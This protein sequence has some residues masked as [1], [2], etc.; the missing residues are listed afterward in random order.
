MEE[1]YPKKRG[2][3]RLQ[4]KHTSEGWWAR[5]T[6]DGVV[7]GE[8]FR[9]N[10]K[11][12]GSKRVAWEAAQAWHKE[13]RELLP[14]LNRKE[15]AQLAKKNNTS[16]YTGVYKSFGRIVDGKRYFWAA[17]W[18][19]DEGKQKHAYFYIDEHGEEKAKEL[20]I[21]ARKGALEQINK[22][23]SNNYWKY[24]R[25]GDLSDEQ[26][27]AK[28]E[29]EYEYKDIFAFEGK[30]KFEIHK[31]HERNKVLRDEKVRRF[32]EEHGKLF[33]E[34]CEFDFEKEYGV[35]GKGLIE[36]HHTVPLSEMS[37]NHRTSITELMC[38]CS[39]C[40][41]TVHNGD[42][43]TNLRKMKFITNAKKKKANK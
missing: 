4:Y 18:A 40:H 35:I 5:Y 15:Y 7:F 38:I 11:R 9:D 10:D 28:I 13:V 31:T 3:T 21:K 1:N 37:D 34:I 16:G 14:P 43:V 24:R 23:W 17:H 30:E 19:E 25:D 26:P 2:I 20:A 6:R 36:V 12:Y 32:L 33:C 41:F 42:H 29:D 39:N 27:S 22:E 8:V